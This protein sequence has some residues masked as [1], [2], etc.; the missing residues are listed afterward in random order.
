[1]AMARPPMVDTAAKWEGQANIQGFPHEVVIEYKDGQEVS[2]QAENE[3][4]KM[5]FHTLPW[6]DLN[7]FASDEVI[8]GPRSALTQ[9]L[10]K[11]LVFEPNPK[12]NRKKLLRLENPPVAQKMVRKLKQSQSKSGGWVSPVAL[13]KNKSDRPTQLLRH[14]SS[15]TFRKT[16]LQREMESLDLDRGTVEVNFV[17]HRMKAAIKP[18]GA[19][20]FI[21]L[22]DFDKLVKVEAS[23]EEVV[24]LL[25]GSDPKLLR[26]GKELEMLTALEKLMTCVGFG[27]APCVCVGVA[28]CAGVRCWLT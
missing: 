13:R 23:R 27:S 3:F 24:D 14:M 4:F 22:D 12:D 17:P 16:Q 25:Q 20:V 10:L 21:G 6:A 5:F 9:R 11:C 26:K 8:V 7:K 15:A 1:M 18:D 19:V 2:I 28:A